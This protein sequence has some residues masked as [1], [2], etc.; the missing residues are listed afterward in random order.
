ML[1]ETMNA[2]SVAPYC[3]IYAAGILKLLCKLK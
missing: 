3:A 2:R 1:L